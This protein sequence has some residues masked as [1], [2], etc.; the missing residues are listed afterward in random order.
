MSLLEDIQKAVAEAG[1]APPEE[2]MDHVTYDDQG[3]PLDLSN[4]EPLKVVDDV[5]VANSRWSTVRMAVFNRGNEN[6][7][8][9]Y[10]EPAT[11]MQDWSDWS[12]S[13]TEVYEVIGQEVTKIR[14]VRA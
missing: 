8:Y 14:Y 11:E 2:V 5:W 9:V 1:N 10:N 6:V 3:N 13:D 12:A 7:A 4:V